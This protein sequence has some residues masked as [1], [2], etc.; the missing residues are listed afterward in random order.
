M[1]RSRKK[2]CF[3][4]LVLVALIG[5]GAWYYQK[6]RHLNATAVSVALSDASILSLNT[7]LPEL[8]G[9]IAVAGGATLGE[10]QA[11]LKSGYL[12]VRNFILDGNPGSLSLIDVSQWRAGLQ[13]GE[14]E[15]LSQPSRTQ[16]LAFLTTISKDKSI[17]PESL[18][19][20]KKTAGEFMGYAVP[21]RFNLKYVQSDDGTWQG[22]S[23]F[24]LQSNTNAP[25]P[26]Y[27][28]VLYNA[29]TQRVAYTTVF[30]PKNVPEFSIP[31]DTSHFDIN[32][33]PSPTPTETEASDT[34]L[35]ATFTTKLDAAD[36]SAFSF[37]SL[38]DQVTAMMTSIHDTAGN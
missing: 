26:S 17:S 13:S 19:L 33:T 16:A 23:F 36:R 20:F 5:A 8:P 31:E 4:V 29:V 10:S 6:A 35:K 30:I 14:S 38:L 27:Y 24:N 25:N 22:M 7:S 34:N 28:A 32:A 18:A 37:K 1:A 21:Y 3:W 11:K 2:S 12:S 15:T 9:F